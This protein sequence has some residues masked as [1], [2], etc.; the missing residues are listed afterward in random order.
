MEE[1]TSRKEFVSRIKGALIGIAYGDAFGMPTEMWTPKQIAEKTGRIEAFRSGHPDNPISKKLKKGEVTDDT[2]NSVLVI[3]MLAKNKGRVNS[4]QFIE[5]LK[6]WIC[7]A[8]KSSTVVGP[9]T[10]RAID[11]IDQGVLMSETG[12]TGTTNGGAMKILPVGLAAGIR[13]ARSGHGLDS[14]ESQDLLEEVEKLC[15]PTHNTSCAIG[16]AAAVAAGGA[17][18]VCGETR[19]DLIYEYMI[20]MAERGEQLGYPVCGPSI[21]SR[22]RMNRYFADHYSLE[23]AQDLI[24]QYSGTGLPSTESVPAAAALFYLAN[25][26][27]LTCARYT[28]NIGG[29]TDTMGAMA[30]GICGAVSTADSYPEEDVRMLERVNGI[31]F[32]ELTRNL[33]GCC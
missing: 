3:E 20:S 26:D 2:I 21:A 10:R 14:K 15:M 8:P 5:R 25:G 19:V 28:A 7:S 16:A 27:P 31:S 11:L 1:E 6:E 33:I 32:D 24:Y 18:A 4:G 23:E 17:M 22:M 13:A 29:D 9:S 30:C 12:K